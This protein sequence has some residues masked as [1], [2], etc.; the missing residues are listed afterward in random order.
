MISWEWYK[1]F[2][3]FEQA[4]FAYGSQ[5]LGSSQFLMLPKLPEKTKLVLKVVKMDSKIII[6]RHESKSLTHSVEAI[7]RVFKTYVSLRKTSLE[8]SQSKK[9]K[10]PKQGFKNGSFSCF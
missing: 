1:V 3:R 5:V 4:K 6:S 10:P 7:S 9:K 2:H 8:S